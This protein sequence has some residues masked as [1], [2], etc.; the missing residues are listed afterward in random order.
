MTWQDII[1]LHVAG[2]TR[3]GGELVELTWSDVPESLAELADRMNVSLDSQFPVEIAPSWRGAR[4]LPKLRGRRGNRIRL[5]GALAEDF[6]AE[7]LE[8]VL[9]HE[10]A[11]LKCRHWELLLLG[12]VLAALGGVSLGLALHVPEVVRSVVGG[13]VLVGGFAGMSWASEFE[14]DGIAARYVG[15]STVRTM[16]RELR[17]LRFR[18]WPELTHPTD[19]LRLKYLDAA[20]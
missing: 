8:G 7:A 14:A 12:C 2:P 5:G 9:A 15:R 1:R 17:L 6:S 20:H 16:L 4:A 3:H 13:L 10:L 11:H 19:T 18:R